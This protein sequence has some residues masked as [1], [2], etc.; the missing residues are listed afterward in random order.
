MKTPHT[1][2]QRNRGAVLLEY[3]VVGVLIVAA[4]VLGVLV[5][6]RAIFFGWDVSG[7]GST[8]RHESAKNAR[9]GYADQVKKD[10][11]QAEKYHDDFHE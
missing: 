11:Q 8:G 1:Q 7:V 9:Q 6:S 2:K 4:C 10:A 3:V 5:L